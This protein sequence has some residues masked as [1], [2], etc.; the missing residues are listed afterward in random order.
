MAALTSI[1]TH[2]TKAVAAMSPQVP[3][4]PIKLVV[5][6]QNPRHDLLHSEKVLA[7]KEFESIAR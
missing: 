4:E 1:L 5:S 3:L 2:L 7:D 6:T